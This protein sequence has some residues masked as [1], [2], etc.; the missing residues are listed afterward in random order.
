MKQL[1]SVILGTGVTGS[2][3]GAHTLIGSRLNLPYAEPSVLGPKIQLWLMGM[4]ASAAAERA[5]PVLQ[6]CHCAETSATIVMSLT[7][8]SFGLADYAVHA[9]DPWMEC[10]SL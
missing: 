2:C 6:L 3:A 10:L 1:L 5:T 4:P 7:Q 8:M 9:R